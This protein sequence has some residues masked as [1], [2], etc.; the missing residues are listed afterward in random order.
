MTWADFF[1]AVAAVFTVVIAVF[2]FLVWRT[3]ERMARFTGAMESHSELMLR[4]RAKECGIKVIAWDQT[5]DVYPKAR[6][7]HGQEIALEPICVAV[8]PEL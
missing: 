1:T 6:K 2:T 4:L 7:A 8:D 3:Y 5:V